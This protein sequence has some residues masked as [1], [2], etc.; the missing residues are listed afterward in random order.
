M[1]KQQQPESVASA[2]PFPMPTPPSAHAVAYMTGWKAGVA[3]RLPEYPATSLIE[4]CER[5]YIHGVRSR[6]EQWATAKANYPLTEG[7]D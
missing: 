2:G 3:G 1:P 7:T 6:E 4:A 5:G